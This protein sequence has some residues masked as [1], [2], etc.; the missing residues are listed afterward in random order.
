MAPRVSQCPR[1]RKLRPLGASA[2]E[3]T[4]SQVC[5]PPRTATPLP[6]EPAQP[7]KPASREVRVAN[8]WGGCGVTLPR[9]LPVRA[10][11][12]GFPRTPGPDVGGKGGDCCSALR[13]GPSP[14]R[15]LGG[16]AAP[17]SAGDA[18]GPGGLR[19]G[20]GLRC[21]ARAA[22]SPSRRVSAEARGGG[23]AEQGAGAKNTRRRRRRRDD[24]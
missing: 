10:S 7:R 18:P 12:A 24:R 4:G 21:G 20:G 19:A 13:P 22:P 14:A 3:G 2:S 5:M 17:L 8:W 1:V 16:S 6:P 11:P 23:A 9:W 15:G